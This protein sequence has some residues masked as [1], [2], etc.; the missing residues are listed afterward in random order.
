M[1]Q[2]RII[3]VLA[4]FVLPLY[5]FTE[6]DERPA[7]TGNIHVVVEGI[8]DI[9]GQIGILL[10]DQKEGFPTDHR[11]ALK[12]VLIPHQD[13]KISYSFHDIPYGNYA[14]SVMHDSNMNDKLDSNLFGIP[15]EGIGVS[16]NAK[17]I[18]SA[19]KF[20]DASFLLESSEITKTIELSY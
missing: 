5:S 2:V 1:M 12:Q 19:P 3:F 14:I 6:T 8:D 10:F 18:L 7:S 11:K 13:K 9:E 20:G 4:L 16:N 15:K 17:G